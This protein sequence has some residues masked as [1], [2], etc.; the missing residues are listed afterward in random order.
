M[1]HFELE[2]APGIRLSTHPDRVDRRR[3]WAHRV[4]VS[5]GP[6]SLEPGARHR[7][8]WRRGVAAQPDGVRVAPAPPDGE[9]P[10]PGGR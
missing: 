5:P 9:D 10:A 6:L 8:T 1:I 7:S 3:S 4:W 2:P